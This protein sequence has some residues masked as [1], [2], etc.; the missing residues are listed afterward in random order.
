[1]CKIYMEDQG[2]LPQNVLE[3]SNILENTN[4]G[5]ATVDIAYVNVMC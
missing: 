5:V 1:M 4:D 3:V 2:C